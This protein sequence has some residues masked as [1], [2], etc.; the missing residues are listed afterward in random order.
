MRAAPCTASQTSVFSEG[1]SRK[2]RL[3][4]R[5]SHFRLPFRLIGQ[6]DPGARH[7]LD[8]LDAGLNG[9][10][11][12]TGRRAAACGCRHFYMNHAVITDLNRIDH[13]EIDEIDGKLRVLNRA[14]RLAHTSFNSFQLFGFHG[15]S[16]SPPTRIMMR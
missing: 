1:R 2:N 4:F 14:Q 16:A 15:V 8:P 9:L 6:F 12:K 3:Y 10:R 7:P 5:Y 11:E 13:A